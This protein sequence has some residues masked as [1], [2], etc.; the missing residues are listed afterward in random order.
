MG[1][2]SK[3]VREWLQGLLVGS[4]LSSFDLEE[5]DSA[6][7]GR[8]GSL[9]GLICWLGDW[10]RRGRWLRSDQCPVFL[11]DLVSF[12]ERAAT[13]EEED[14]QQSSEG[15]PSH[16]EHG[17]THLGSDSGVVELVSHHHRNSGLTSHTGR[18]GD[19]TERHKEDNNL[20]QGFP[21]EL[22]QQTDETHSGK[23]ESHQNQ[24]EREPGQVVVGI[25]IAHKVLG[26]GS[27]VTKVVIWRQGLVRAQGT[28]LTVRVR[29]VVGRVANT[30][31][32]PSGNVASIANLGRLS[33]DPV[34]LVERERGHR[35]RENDEK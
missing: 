25:S 22:E 11:V 19:Q 7:V 18:T 31:E 10:G 30:P 14:D 33:L 23:H 17:R 13:G 4:L 20:L 2:K 24:W 35:T 15:S 8:Q 26:Q 32:S 12:V 6:L 34:K 1:M 5:S 29:V 21:A 3:Q 16:T 28:A 9:V 27:G